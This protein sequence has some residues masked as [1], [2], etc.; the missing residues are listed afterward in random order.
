MATR[1]TETD[2]RPVYDEVVRQVR[3]AGLDLGVAFDA[4]SSTVQDGD[5]G[6]SRDC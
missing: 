6:A 1:L 5:P 4:P 3:A 2:P